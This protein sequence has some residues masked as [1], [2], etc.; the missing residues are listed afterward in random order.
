MKK[1]NQSLI[2]IALLVLIWGAS[3]PIYKVSVPYITPLF[4]AG[5]RAFGGGLL[6]TIIIWKIRDQLNFKKNWFVYMGAAIF[7]TVLYL[8]LQTIGLNYL[9]GGMFS[10]LVY[11]QPVLLG[12]LAWL[13][14]KEPMTVQKLFGL[15]LGFVG[16]AV[17][18][19]D[20]I[21]SSFQIIGI[22]L[23]LL[24]AFFWAFGIVFVKKYA[25]HVNSYWVVAMQLM[26]GGAIL[27]IWS[28]STEN[29]STIVWNRY[30]ISSILFG[31]TLGL[32]FAYLIYYKLIREGEASK[33]GA[34]TFLVPI[35]AVL[36]SVIF[37]GE[38]LTAT[39]VCGIL[40]VLISIRIVNR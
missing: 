11:F 24:T 26:I 5:I 27:L 37:L 8:S 9:P 30:V 13:I 19:I 14:L 1:K 31:I 6:L 3:W 17:V 35:V 28:F 7:N 23:A 21:S 29:L 10:I 32:T 25:D 39:M 33:V 40:L 2:Y 16:I 34:A 15:L 36:I 38:T 22:V 18:S 20:G 4:F 12:L